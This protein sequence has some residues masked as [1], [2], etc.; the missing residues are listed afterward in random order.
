MP[1]TFGV[2]SRIEIVYLRVRKKKN[3]EYHWCVGA[4]LIQRSRFDSR[5]YQIFRD[6]LGLERGPLCLVNASEELTE[7]A[8]VA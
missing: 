8:S 6:V 1:E 3:V 4:T 2:E 7:W 5:R